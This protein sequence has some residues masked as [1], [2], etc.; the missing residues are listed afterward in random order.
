MV[1]SL[2]FSPEGSS[3]WSPRYVRLSDPQRC[4]SYPNSVVPV[5]CHFE[6]IILPRKRSA[7][8][9][10]LP[11]RESNTLLSHWLRDA[12]RESIIAGNLQPKQKIPSS[13]ELA[14]QYSL[15]RGTVL[16]GLEE[17]KAEGYLSTVRGSGVYVSTVLPDSLMQRKITSRRITSKTH[18]FTRL[19]QY[20]K[21][22]KPVSYHVNSLSLAFRTNLPALDL[23]PT[24]LWSRIAA[25][26][27]RRASSN[28]LLGCVAGGYGPFKEVVAQYLRT[29]R[30]VRCEVEQIVIVS[31][32]QEAVDLTARLLLDPGD[33]VLMEDPGYHVSAAA[34]EAV[35]ARVV[36]VPVDKEGAAPSAQS[37]HGARLLY[38]TPGHQCPTGVTMSLARRVEILRRARDSQTYIFEDDHDSE[39]R[40]SGGPLPAMQSIDQNNLVIFGGSFNKVLFPSLRMGYMVLPPALVEVF[41]RTKFINSR[42]HSLL[43][44]VIMQ[45]FIEKGHFGRHLR[46]MRKI[47]AQRHEA[48]IHHAEKRLSGLLSLSSVEAGLQTIG[49]LEKGLS[50]EDVCS[51]AAKRNIDVIAIDRFIRTAVVPEGVQIGFAAV[52][53]NA[54]EKG[55][56]V[57]GEVMDDLI[58]STSVS[59]RVRRRQQ[60]I[61]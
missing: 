61:Y 17:L 33:R 37:F 27:L 3:V 16:A 40:Y 25:Q 35:G 46:R 53:E 28:Q 13:R 52:S 49:W 9:L 21:R 26:R 30:T 56:Q 51:A 38:L 45:E 44:Q 20:A 32:V 58:A 12:I 50:A 55:I 57:L 11:A 47:Y 42:H 24:S 39:F 43:D 4:T 41:Q 14:A 15:S 60:R 19:S 7:F 10:T 23:F 8:S 54:I 29:S 59:N 34:F 22:V 6:V 36:G 2:V 1:I 18:D 5:V 31:G 48:L